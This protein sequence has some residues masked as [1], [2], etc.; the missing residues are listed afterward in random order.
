MLAGRVEAVCSFTAHSVVAVDLPPEEVRA[1]LD[2]D[3]LGSAMSAPFLAWVSE[4]TGAKIGAL[5]AVLVAPAKAEPAIDLIRRDDLLG[6]P[7]VSR[8]AVYR[9]ELRVFSDPSGAGVLVIGRGLAGRLEMSFEVDEPV[10]GAGL[11]RRLAASAPQ[12]LQSDE[13][14]FAQCSPGNAGSLRALIAA[15][16]VPIGSECLFLRP[17]SGSDVG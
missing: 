6:H 7:R 14:L 9:T 15:G 1:R 3:D 5:D 13:P 4:A 16:Y 17:S 12:A 10:R 11:G 2:P 8:A